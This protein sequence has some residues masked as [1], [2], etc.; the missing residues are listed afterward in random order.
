MAVFRR[1]L[2]NLIKAHPL[3]DSMAGKMMRT[4]ELANLERTYCLVE[5]QAKYNLALK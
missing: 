1:T 5:N 3:K 4:G 2:L